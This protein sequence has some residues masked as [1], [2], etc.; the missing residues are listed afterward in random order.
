MFSCLTS[1]CRSGT[2]S[3]SEESL[4]G[5]CGFP[6]KLVDP[7]QSLTCN[8]RSPHQIDPRYEC[9]LLMGQFKL[10]SEYQHKTLFG[11][12]KRTMGTYFLWM[13]DHR[14]EIMKKT[15]LK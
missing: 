7:N 6:W 5:G 13:K 11:A 9:N 8:P 14:D 3:R 1:G 10:K 2:R 12:P 15:K 4:W